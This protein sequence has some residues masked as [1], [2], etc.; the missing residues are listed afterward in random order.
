[1]KMIANKMR[2]DQIPTVR[3][4]GENTPFAVQ[5]RESERDNGHDSRCVSVGYPPCERSE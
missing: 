3:G 2:R 1:M 5:S 4:M